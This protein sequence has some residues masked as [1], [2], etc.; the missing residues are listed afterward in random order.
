MA[1]PLKGVK[2]IEMAGIGP[3]P[4]CA[5]MLADMGAQ[6]LRIERPGTARARATDILVRSRDVVA[7]DLA[8][9]GATAA[10]LDMVAGADV[11]I[12]GFRPGVMERLG[13]GPVPC[14]ER[15]PALVYGRMTGWG[16]HG[17]LAH[18]AGHDINYIA[19]TGALH[20]IGRPG[21][22]PT[23]PLN[24]VGD[25]GGGAM[26]L[27][28]GIAA[29]LYEARSSGKG[30]V[31]DAAMTDGA[32]L[33]SAMMYG[34]HAGGAWNNRRGDNMLDGGAHFYDTYECAD[35]KHVAV[36]AIEAKFYARLLALCGIEDEA[37]RAQMDQQ[38]WPE[39]KAKLAGIFRT[40]TRDQWC[41]VL[42]GSDACFAPVLD[43]DEAPRHPHNVA[44]NTFVEV[45]GMIH[46]APAPRFSRT[47]PDAP[48]A[49]REASAEAAPDI[50]AAWGLRDSTI[51]ALQQAKALG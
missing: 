6:V 44:R 10:V 43:W 25:F 30:Q 37:F 7:M 2:V 5:M 41:E 20:A 27:A 47:E 29:A 14:L 48:R 42:E 50:L 34:M 26:M 3:G 31:V 23:V 35:G 36:G 40:R 8:A 49:P 51:D 21:A 17:P 28:F 33:L 39:L 16:Q 12:E 24:Y 13:L 22:N 45:E 1:G 11:L 46:P 15:R 19:I 9:P 38:A 18:A 4:F 32:A